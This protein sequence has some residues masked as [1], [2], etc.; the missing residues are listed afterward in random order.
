MKK[1]K[2]LQDFLKIMKKGFIL[3]L[4]FLAF[5]SK[6]QTNI[7]N[8]VSIG[9]HSLS[10][11]ASVNSVGIESIETGAIFNYILH[12]TVF[13]DRSIVT[14]TDQL[15]PELEF[16]GIATDIDVSIPE[17]IPLNLDPAI[18]NSNLITITLQSPLPT[19]QPTTDIDYTGASTLID[20]L[21]PVRFIGGTT[22]NGTIATN[23]ATIT[24]NGQSAT[25]N[26]ITV[27]AIAELNWVVN[28]SIQHPT[29]KD[30]NNNWIVQPGGTV[31]YKI[32]VQER[33]GYKNTGVLNLT[34]LSILD[35]PQPSNVTFNIVSI[36]SNS[37]GINGNNFPPQ[38]NFP[39]DLDASKSLKATGNNT[40]V[41]IFV[42]VTY[43]NNITPGECLGNIVEVSAN[44]P[45]LSGNNTFL[46]SS[47][48]I[49]GNGADKDCVTVSNYCLTNDCNTTVFE[50]RLYMRSRDINCSGIYQ[51]RFTNKSTTNEN[52]QNIIIEDTFPNE[53]TVNKILIGNGS[54][55]YSL[56]GGATPIPFNQANNLVI[57]SGIGNSIKVNYSNELVP[58]SFLYVNLYFTINN[59]T[60]PG[61]IIQNEAT[62][63]YSFNSTPP[64]RKTAI[65]EFEVEEPNPEICIQKF[66]CGGNDQFY[67]PGEIIRY[68]LAVVN[69]GTANLNNVE[70]SDILDPN[71]TY[72]GSPSFYSTNLGYNSNT[73]N[74]TLGGNFTSWP[75]TDNSSGS[76]L[77]WNISTIDFDCGTGNDPYY[78]VC[79]SATT[80]NRYKKYYIEF[81]VKINDN[82]PPGVY[83]NNFTI[84]GDELTTA[85]TSNSTKINVKKLS[86]ITVKKLQS[87]D[88]GTTW[89]DSSTSLNAT[90][91]QNVLYRLNVINV[92]NLEFKNLVI[93]DQLPNVTYSTGTASITDNSNTAIAFTENNT[94]NILTFSSPS[95]FIFSN[96]DEFNIDIP[97]T[98]ATNAQNRSEICNSF[99]FTGV[100]IDDR[101]DPI[102]L[103]PA[104]VCIKIKDN[105]PGTD[106][107]DQT[108]TD[109]DGVGDACDNCPDI[110]NKDQTDT[111]GDGIGDVC[112]TNCIDFENEYNKENWQGQNLKDIL[113]DEDE[114]RG[115]FISFVDGPDM[116]GV[117]NNKDFTGDWLKNY[118]GNCMCFDFKLDYKKEDGI[119]VGT[120]PQLIIYTGNSINSFQQLAG[121]VRAG[122]VGN[123]NNPQIEPY[124][125]KNYCLPIY[126]ATG[127]QLPSNS[128]GQWVIYSIGSVTPLSGSAAVTAWNNLIQNVTG[129]LFNADYLVGEETISFDNFCASECEIICQ[130]E[131][132]DKDGHPDK[133]DNCP[134]TY[135][136][137]QT[138]TDGDGI[139]DACDNCI[140]TSNP[141]QLDSDGDGEGDLCDPTPCGDD[142]DGDGIGD[143]C[144][145]CPND[146][147]PDQLDSDN[148]G[149]GDVCDEP[150]ITA[151]CGVDSDEDGFGDLCDNCPK[152]ENPDQLDT[153]GDGIGDACDP[154]PCGII[155]TDEDGT[156]DLCDN[157]PDVSNPNQEDTDNDGIGDACEPCIT[158]SDGDGILNNID[159]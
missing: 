74:P 23:T 71:F 19:P 80:S 90:P 91:G 42:D 33:N 137:D 151:P 18:S 94:N 133:C 121:S 106:N 148:D 143:A 67:N 11:S 83:H 47:P 104:P 70:I 117:I 81:D 7:S 122:F 77:Q 73:C 141:D 29:Q 13:G 25:T 28:K 88:N 92:G 103:S 145:N 32:T 82:A 97:V 110:P 8:T 76:N 96:G 41:S 125:W 56:D 22:P 10:K 5:I 85:K 115:T 60:Q 4:L 43:P 63:D 99:T 48:I 140:K 9:N 100:D 149:E 132:K 113:F 95:T 44:Y 57:N 59:S 38:F 40:Y 54:G 155:D 84:N 108:D 2:Y 153:D 154:T 89:T 131:D 55:T 17:F 52:A 150:I 119:D 109:G 144:D 50:K 66:V 79:A 126:E 139:G 75:V 135:N 58:E 98:I 130:G 134:D 27:E 136:P 101:I 146:F 31:R 37:D 3:I 69:F 93:T 61:T 107:L 114:E 159:N 127:N 34:N 147:N 39:F 51:L 46:D 14:L 112:D 105:C 158:D 120:F 30:D 124:V 111:D 36:T 86:G 20:I 16:V 45:T 87:I 1:E 156:P 26:P 21:I 157:C 118:P 6:A 12:A 65:S 64:T 129:I 116:S 35:I 24:N 78:Y 142:F 128:D 138:D 123:P 62:V 15:P 72:M 53:I 68:K 152:T 102:F 49:N